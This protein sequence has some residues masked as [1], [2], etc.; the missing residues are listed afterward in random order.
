MLIF[1]IVLEKNQM[2]NCFITNKATV[3]ITSYSLLI[4]KISVYYIE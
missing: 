3:F 2:A 4:L 1:H